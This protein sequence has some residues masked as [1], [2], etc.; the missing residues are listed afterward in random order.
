MPKIHIA[1]KNDEY[2]CDDCGPSFANGATVKIEDRGDIDMSP[3]AYCYDADSH[4]KL[5][6]YLA[7]LERIGHTPLDAN[8]PQCL[9]LI[10]GFG[11][12]ITEEDGD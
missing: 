8:E 1:W 2:D 12:E 11:Y 3:H 6:V 5:E 9:E 4:S 10:A 7:I